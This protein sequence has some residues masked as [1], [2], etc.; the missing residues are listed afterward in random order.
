[1]IEKHR[2]VAILMSM[3]ARREQVRNVFVLQGV[4]IGVIGSVIGLVAGYGLSLLADHYHWITLDAEVYALSY[5]PF[6]PRWIDAVWVPAAA[7]LVAF[8]ATI[9]P[10]RTATRVDPAEALRYE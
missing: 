8:L 2:D 5:V 9:Y 6:D 7:I 1:V 4:I 3:G 10:A